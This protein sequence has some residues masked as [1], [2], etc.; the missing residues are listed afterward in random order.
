LPIIGVEATVM[1]LGF[2]GFGLAGAIPVILTSCS[3]FGSTFSSASFSDFSASPFSSDFIVG[4]ASCLSPF[5]S[6]SV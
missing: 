1:G 6:F 2:F 5:F 3:G 4:Q